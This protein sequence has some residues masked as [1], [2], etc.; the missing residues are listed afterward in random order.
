MHFDINASLREVK[1]LVV[2]QLTLEV[3][4]SASVIASV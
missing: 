4:S 1:R 2:K 3:H